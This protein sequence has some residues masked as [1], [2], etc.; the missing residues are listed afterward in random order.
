MSTSDTIE[1]DT[2]KKILCA[3]C[4]T[5][6]LGPHCY[7]CGQPVRGMVRH[8]S[9]VLG[10]LFDTLL[11]LD[12][13]IWKTLPSLLFR[14]GFLTAEYFDGRRVRYVSPVRLFIFLCVT[15]FFVVRLSSDWSI[16]FGLDTNSEQAISSAE[17]KVNNALI[18]V[19][20][21]KQASADNPVLK[22]ELNKVQLYLDN[23]VEE[24]QDGIAVVD[25]E[26][27][28][29]TP[30][31][32]AS[33][34]S[35]L[36]QAITEVDREFLQMDGLPEGL[37]NWLNTEV[38]RAQENIERVSDD[39]NRFKKAFLSA[40]PSTLLLMVPLFAI[41]CWIIYLFKRRLYMEHLI[42]AL[43]SHAFICFVLLLTT[44][45]VNI[46]DWLD[47]YSWI[48][49]LCNW[50]LLVLIVWIP[51]YLLLM[52]KKIYQQGWIMTLIKYCTLGISYPLLLILGATLTALYTLAEL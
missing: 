49:I 45:L 7:S 27:D 3:N 31:T 14:P 19:D 47:N 40:L 9:S 41:M 46:Q 44:L 48:T 38:A 18:K 16:N 2:A 34:N 29:P 50:T 39:P 42:V 28:E 22:A 4:Q 43:H 52:Q 17:Q 25:N 6:L 35:G 11:A 15:T 30:V 23:G 5:E 24:L 20:E 37:S 1:M 8:F 36:K 51:I 33:I 21:V 12:S 10:D 13:R 32:K 26:I